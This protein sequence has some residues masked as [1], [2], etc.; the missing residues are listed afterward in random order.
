MPAFPQIIEEDYQRITAALNAFL[1]RS[2]ASNALIVEKAGYLIVECGEEPPFDTAELATLAANAFA[3]TQF[4]ADRLSETNFSSMFQQGEQTSVL[5]TNVE[6]NTL[7]VTV[8]DASQSMGAVKYYAAET[9]A[10][11]ARQISIAQGRD[12]TGGLDLAHLDPSSADDV[13][14]KKSDP[15]DSNE[16]DDGHAPAAK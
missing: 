11:I 16:S 7:L 12:Q 2:E 13:F 1:S 14:R 5:W 15:D 9:A 8:F 6:E 3:A 10:E 4:M